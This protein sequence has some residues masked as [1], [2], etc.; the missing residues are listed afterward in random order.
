[1]VTRQR[2]SARTRATVAIRDDDTVP[3]ISV[4]D[5]SVQENAGPLVF[6]VTV[7]PVPAS[8]VTISWNTENGTATAGSDYTATS[9]GTLT[10]PVGSATG[11]ISIPITDDALLEAD[12][13]F[14]LVITAATGAG[15]PGSSELKA[16]AT[17][18][19]DD[20]PSPDGNRRSVRDRGR[21]GRGLHVR[22]DR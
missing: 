15:V 5:V 9:S 22:Q 6:T 11:T 17:I 14:N 2:A 1:M 19:N 8:L 18:L 16:R 4:E 10:I 7:D 13:H 21:N 12:E 20:L 3:G